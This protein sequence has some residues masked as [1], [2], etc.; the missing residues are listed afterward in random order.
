MGRC[1]GS[2]AKSITK[3]LAVSTKN[4]GAAIHEDE[5]RGAGR[6]DLE[7]RGSRCVADRC[8]ANDERLRVLSDALSA[9]RSAPEIIGGASGKRKVVEVRGI[10]EAEV[11]ARLAAA[12]GVG[13]T[14]APESDFASRFLSS[15][16]R[17][18]TAGCR[19]QHAQ[20]A[21]E[22]RCADDRPYG[23]WGGLAATTSE[24][25]APVVMTVSML[26]TLSRTAPRR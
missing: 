4:T 10:S 9:P 15:S 5:S 16:V 11:V 22:E 8:A 20:D 25:P 19:V 26:R 23:C 12:S 24:M 7:R 1:R 3:C 14:E 6:R 17:Q 2:V 13:R 18:K 21:D